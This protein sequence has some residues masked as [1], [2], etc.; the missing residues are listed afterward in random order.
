MKILNSIICTLILVFSFGCGTK[1][2]N[3]NEKQFAD[4]QII[5]TDSVVFNVDSSDLKY[6]NKPYL[7]AYD[8]ALL[9]WQVPFKERDINT[10]FG[11]AH[12]IICGPENTTPIVL[13]HGM[14][15]SSTMWYTNIKALSEKYQVIAIDFLLEPGKSTNEKEVNETSEIVQWYTEIFDSLNLKSIN[16]IG[17]SRGG[18]LATN[19]ALNYPERINKMVLLSPA[20]TFI[21][22]RPGIDVFYNLAYTLSPK[23][24]RLRS[25]LET[26]TFDVDNIDQTYIDHYFIATQEAT[27]NKCFVQMR[28]F[29]SKELNSLKMPVMVLIGDNDIINNHKSLKIAKEEIKY[30][31][32]AK[33]KNAGHFLS[34]DQADVVNK[35]ILDFIDTQN[36][37]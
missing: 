4:I 10:K 18:W 35:R 16:L 32:V 22:I 23:R 34:I 17:A 20:Q 19:I 30:V 5:N 6:K 29:S 31:N 24:K 15:A 1:N 3:D 21:W 25:V 26:M 8:R 27:I 33:I 7:L 28:P 14:N 9:L 13:L 2:P 11:K 36:L 12:V 37:K